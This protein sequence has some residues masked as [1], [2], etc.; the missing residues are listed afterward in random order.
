[1]V[2]LSLNRGQ[3]GTW[4]VKAAT[5]VLWLLAAGVVAFW[6]MRLG[7]GGAGA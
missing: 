2:T 5:F 4:H 1:M 6:A 3:A 7:N